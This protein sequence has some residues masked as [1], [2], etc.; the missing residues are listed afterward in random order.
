MP[1]NVKKQEEPKS[2][3]TLYKNGDI[4]EDKGQYNLF[5]LY[6]DLGVLRSMEQLQEYCE[7]PDN[8]DEIEEKQVSYPCKLTYILP[9]E[10][11]I[12]MG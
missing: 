1:K 12:Q 5:R 9:M 4:K 6:K 3:E 7:N 11:Q 10:R 2:W 8:K